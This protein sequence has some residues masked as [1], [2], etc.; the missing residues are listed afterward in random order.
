MI[1]PLPKTIYQCSSCKGVSIKFYGQCPFCKNWNTLEPQTVYKKVNPIKKVS[2]KRKAKIVK[3]QGEPSELDKWFED[4]AVEARKHPFC[5]NCGDNVS[6][7]LN[8]SDTKIKRSVHGHICP[9]KTFKSIMCHKDNHVL[10]CG[11]F[12]NNQCHAEADSTQE[13]LRQMPVFKIMCERVKLFR[14]L[15]T[16]KKT[17]TLPFEFML[18]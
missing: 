1:K 12:S 14:D 4:R 15:I 5:E 9:K 8:H 18:P 6:Y 11:V 16:E 10:L 7:C 17:H 3:L 2:D 13:N